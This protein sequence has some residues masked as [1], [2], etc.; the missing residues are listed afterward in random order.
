MHKTIEAI[1]LYINSTVYY[2]ALPCSFHRNKSCFIILSNVSGEKTFHALLDSGSER[3]YPVREEVFTSCDVPQFC[4]C[5]IKTNQTLGDRLVLP[6]STWLRDPLGQTCVLFQTTGRL[7]S[8][9]VI[10][11]RNVAEMY[12]GLLV[13]YCEVSYWCEGK[14]L[15]MKLM[16]FFYTETHPVLAD[17]GKKNCV[18]SSGKR[19]ARKSWIHMMRTGKTLPVVRYLGIV[20]PQCV[21]PK[22]K[23]GCSCYL[24]PTSTFNDY[25]HALICKSTI[26]S[27]PP[28]EIL[29]KFVLHGN[30]YKPAVDVI[31]A[32]MEER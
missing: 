15:D 14:A 9:A 13:I 28:C 30:R 12:L 29:K 22:R 4:Y 25:T 3:W 1:I 24:V 6:F 16:K 23:K 32:R 27:V 31:L 7:Y 18:K 21:V 17:V 19:D 11:E 5:M 8:P 2:N 26:N 20:A 10:S